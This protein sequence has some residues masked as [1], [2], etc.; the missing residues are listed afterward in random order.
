MRFY[1]NLKQTLHTVPF[2][3]QA[4]FDFNARLILVICILFFFAFELCYFFAI[5]QKSNQKKLF[6]KHYLSQ[7][8]KLIQNQLPPAD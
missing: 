5:A 6:C 3:T 2:V 4:R 8:L 7:R 1:F